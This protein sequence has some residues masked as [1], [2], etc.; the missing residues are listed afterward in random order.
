MRETGVL[1]EEKVKRGNREPLHELCKAKN[2]FFSLL[3]WNFGRF[4][5]FFFLFMM[6]LLVWFD[7][8]SVQM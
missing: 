7:Y 2:V 5:L 6:L 8:S 1:E 4:F 3:I